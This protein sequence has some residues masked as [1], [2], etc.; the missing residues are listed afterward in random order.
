MIRQSAQ[1][2]RKQIRRS[3][4]N[5]YKLEEEGPSKP[6]NV[7]SRFRTGSWCRLIKKKV[8]EDP[9]FH[10]CVA[11]A[12]QLRRLRNLFGGGLL[13]W[14]NMITAAL[15]EVDEETEVVTHQ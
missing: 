12:R 6:P 7:A 5:R 13:T 9:H 4:A 8:A 14:R 2:V 11:Q 10:L 15:E 1:K 3:E